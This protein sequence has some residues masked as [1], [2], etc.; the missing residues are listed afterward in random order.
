M[1]NVI[2]ANL[3]QLVL[4]IAQL[5]WTGQLTCMLATRDYEEYA[6]APG[7]NDSKIPE[8]VEGRPLRVTHPKED[9]EQ[10]K[11]NMP[12]PYW[13][14]TTILWT[15]I[16]WFASQAVF[17]V[18]I[19]VLDHWQYQT[20]WSVLQVGYSVLGRY[21]LGSYMC[22]EPEL[23]SFNAIRHD[24]FHGCNL[25]H[26]RLGCEDRKLEAVQPSAACRYLQRSN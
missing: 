15:L 18:K 26:L 23:I 19:D 9:T 14:F 4:S 13:L 3:P 20:G 5:W 11:A 7:L 8:D 1:Q 17:F 2:F 16:P 6:V 10:T 24:P 22:L 25:P 12:K 21:A